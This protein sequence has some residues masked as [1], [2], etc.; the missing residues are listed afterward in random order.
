MRQ[1]ATIVLSYAVRGSDGERADQ[2]DGRHGVRLPDGDIGELRRNVGHDVQSAAAATPR[3]QNQDRLEQD[4][5]LLNRKRAQKP[6][7][8]K[9]LRRRGERRRMVVVPPRETSE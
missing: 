2:A 5:E 3:D 6:V 4:S 8:E 1:L 9:E 7:I